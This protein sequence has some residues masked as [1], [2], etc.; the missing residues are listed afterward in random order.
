MKIT[1]LNGS[2]T[3]Q[4]KNFTDVVTIGSGDECKLTV[5]EPGVSYLHATL[6]EVEGDWYIRHY[7]NP[8]GVFVNGHKSK[9]RTK[10]SDGDTIKLSTVELKIEVSNSGQINDFEVA[11]TVKEWHQKGIGRKIFWWWLK[12]KRY[13]RN[14]RQ[15]RGNIY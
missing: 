2:Q 15:P 1:F 6:L 13:L 7:D 8:I 3:G 11:S 5:A 10:V 12:Y 4:S 9:V 14:K